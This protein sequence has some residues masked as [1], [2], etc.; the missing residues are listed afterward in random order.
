MS[1]NY[2]LKGI[3]KDLNLLAQIPIPL[4]HLINLVDGMQ[5]SRMVLVSELSAN[6]RQRGTC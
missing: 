6:L 2:L 1:M 4:N 5:D 3:D